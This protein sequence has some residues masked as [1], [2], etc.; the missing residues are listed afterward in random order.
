M[1]WIALLYSVV[2]PEG[3]RLKMADLKG[4]AEELGYDRV[5]TVA[6]SGNLLFDAERRDAAGLEA[7]LEAAFVKRFGKTV[8]VILRDAA[9][10]RALIRANPFPDVT[11]LTQVSVRIM[12]AAYPDS[13]TGDLAPYIADERV[14]LVD[15]DLFIHFPGQPGRTR[16]LTAFGTRRFSSTGTFRT[17]AMLHRISAEA[18]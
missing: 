4:L 14:A 16:L 1:T 11:D 10:L 3:A 7:E 17:L 15:G 5:R 12:R 18:G 9:R 6:S 13:V 8:P 2:L